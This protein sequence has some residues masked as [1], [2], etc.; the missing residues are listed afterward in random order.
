MLNAGEA[1]VCVDDTFYP[2]SIPFSGIGVSGSL[3]DIFPD[4]SYRNIRQVWHGRAY[5]AYRSFVPSQVVLMI[6][7]T[8]A[9]DLYRSTIIMNPALAAEACSDANV[10]SVRLARWAITILQF[11][12]FRLIEVG[13]GQRISSGYVVTGL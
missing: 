2:R 4:V 5:L 13:K 1:T 10:K 7:W 6:S 8:L 12:L 3:F 11:V 9:L